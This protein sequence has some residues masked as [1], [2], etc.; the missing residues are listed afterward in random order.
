MLI[1]SM[2]CIPCNIPSTVTVYVCDYRRGMDW[3]MDL[4]MDLLTTPLG[5]AS[6]Y[7]A[8]DGL[9]NLKITTR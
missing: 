3:L 4:L 7:S 2:Q 5:T 9:H 1:N 6:N 8:I